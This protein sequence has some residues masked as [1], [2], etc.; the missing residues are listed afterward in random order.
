MGKKERPKQTFKHYFSVFVG[1]TIAFPTFRVLEENCKQFSALVPD[2]G[3]VSKNSALNISKYRHA[4]FAPRNDTWV[5]PYKMVCWLYDFCFV[6][7]EALATKFYPSR[8]ATQNPH[9]LR[10]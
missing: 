4:M 3:V 10:W 1:R 5:V 8:M 6:L 7:F 9:S 2:E